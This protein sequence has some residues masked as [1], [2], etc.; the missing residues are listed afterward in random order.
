MSD[1][2]PATLN[3]PIAAP[4]SV[5]PAPAPEPAILAEAQWKGPRASVS[6]TLEQAGPADGAAFRVV[7]KHRD[8]LESSTTVWYGG[9]DLRAAVREFETQLDWL[10]REPRGHSDPP[11]GGGPYEER[12]LVRFDHDGLDKLLARLP[13]GAPRF[14]PPREPTWPT[15]RTEPAAL[16][17]QAAAVL[18]SMREQVRGASPYR[19]RI[20]ARHPAPATDFDAPPDPEAARAAERIEARLAALDGPAPAAVAAPEGAP[21][22]EAVSA[23]PREVQPAVLERIESV[24]YAHAADAHGAEEAL[25]A[26]ARMIA[27]GAERAVL[28]SVREPGVGSGEAAALAARA[29]LGERGFQAERDQVAELAAGA[30]EARGRL[31]R[32][33]DRAAEVLEMR[34]PGTL[35][36]DARTDAHEVLREVERRRAELARADLERRAKGDRTVLPAGRPRMQ[37]GGKFQDIR[38]IDCLRCGTTAGREDGRSRLHMGGTPK[39][40]PDGRTER[41]APRDGEVCTPCW[42]NGAPMSIPELKL[43]QRQARLLEGAQVRFSPGQAG[44]DERAAE[45]PAR[46]RARRG[47][48]SPLDERL[49]VPSPWVV[50]P[51]PAET[52]DRR[53]EALIEREALREEALEKGQ[54]DL[55]EGR[56]A[57]WWDLKFS[58]MFAGEPEARPE[59][60]PEQRLKLET[61][62]LAE[63]ERRLLAVV[64]VEDPA[65]RR[66]LE[67]Q[68]A[69]RLHLAQGSAVR[70]AWEQTR[71]IPRADARA[72]ARDE[73]RRRFLAPETVAH[74]RR[75]REARGLVLPKDMPAEMQ[76]AIRARQVE[77]VLADL[78][79]PTLVRRTREVARA[80]TSPEAARAAAELLHRLR[81]ALADIRLQGAVASAQLAETARQERGVFHSGLDEAVLTGERRGEA[82]ERAIDRWLARSDREGTLAAGEVRSARELAREAGDL[83]PRRERA[84][85]TPS[86]AEGTLP[87]QLAERDA[88]I[89]AEV[90]KGGHSAP[91]RILA[92]LEQYRADV[93]ARGTELGDPFGEDVRERLVESAARQAGFSQAELDRLWEIQALASAAEDPHA[94][95]QLMREAGAWKADPELG[96][97]PARLRDALGLRTEGGARLVFSDDDRALLARAERAAAPYLDVFDEYRAAWREEGLRAARAAEH[98]AL[99]EG[100]A[101]P[102]VREAIQAH[103]DPRVADLAGQLAALQEFE[104]IDPAYQEAM[105]QIGRAEAIVEATRETRE[106]AQRAWGE[107]EQTVKAQFSNPEK[108]LKAVREMDAGEVRQ[109]AAK[110]RT[111][112]LALSAN[113]PRTGGSPRIPGIN[114]A[115]AAEPL[116]SHLKTVRAQGLRGLMGHVDTGA[117][118]RQARVAAV[119][120]ETWAEAR[121]RGEQMRAW[122]APQLGLA[123][124]T[125]LA[126]VEKA[127]LERLAELTATHRDLVRS[128]EQLTPVPTLAQ[129]ERRLKA[130]DPGTASLA[131]SAL[132][133]LAGAPRHPAPA[134]RPERTL[135][136]PALSR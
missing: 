8:E 102:A 36:A 91:D 30:W 51:S 21:P 1:V 124:D 97:D 43:A 132:P 63:A 118:E 56:E 127:A 129:I 108:L 99:V 77:R 48:A 94:F 80:A 70:E 32:L 55:P 50:Q 119:A 134:E 54:W 126:R 34:R 84:D 75:L 103:S 66:V 27:P 20:L 100:A 19:S 57:D 26:R 24:V 49:D 25:R 16:S 98:Q 114:A 90:A 58:G 69:V 106:G 37:E 82:H 112:P 28:A 14:A 89:A 38:S 115:G 130:M 81:P 17:P 65:L 13:Q 60:S 11:Q 62:R 87:W 68:A 7:E 5:E 39:T 47:L 45:W 116:E 41:Y 96:N 85:H 120:L 131:R 18:Q 72:A 107:V 92:A 95:D 31:D 101:H 29:A 3:P 79:V 15:R 136:P 33:V 86:R 46:A 104:R 117:T 59:P 67:T 52:A 6:L 76:A 111:N 128:W 44:W 12:T 74:H 53:V 4:V 125:P 135:A 10:A 113:H 42:L 40:D 64:G 35:P 61:E 23:A 22:A 2:T 109:L 88:V 83:N 123:A 105:G 73:V 71:G 93:A 110:L 133:E 9:G 121:Q 78:D 122:A